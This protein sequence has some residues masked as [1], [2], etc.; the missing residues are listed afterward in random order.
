MEGKE[1]K[2]FMQFTCEKEVL[3]HLVIVMC[4]ILTVLVFVEV[5]RLKYPSD[6]PLRHHK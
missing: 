1:K 3:F 5:L 4:L 6:F 2:L